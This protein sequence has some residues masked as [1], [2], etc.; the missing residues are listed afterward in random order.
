[1]SFTSLFY[2]PL[3]CGTAV[4][5]YFLGEK[6]RP[7]FLLGVSWFVYGMFGLQHFLLLLFV[8]GVSFAVG[9]FMKENGKKNKVF[10]AAGTVIVAGVL[11]YMK[12]LDMFLVWGEAA[13]GI[14]G[15]EMT[16][17][18]RH[19]ILP[20]G[21]SFYTFQAISYM[22]DVYRG[23]RQERN[24]VRYALYISFFPQ[25]VAG[26]IEQ[27]GWL[28]PQINGKRADRCDVSAGIR[29]LLSGYMRKFVIA[30][31]MAGFVD[32]AYGN[33]TQQGG[34][35]LAAATVF[36][37]I[38]IYCD[39]SGYTHIAIGSA[40]LLGIRLTENFNRPYLAEG[41]RDFWGRWHIT[42]TRWFREYVYIPLGGNRKGVKRKYLNIMAVF[43]LSGLWHGAS[44]TFILWG[45][46]F[47]I[48]RIVED[49]AGK[50]RKNV[51]ADQKSSVSAVWL[52]RIGTFF[53]V[54]TAWV[55]FRSQNVTEA[56]EVL[57]RI[58]TMSGPGFG[59]ADTMELAG[60]AARI[61]VL[62]VLPRI[63]SVG[64]GT[65][66][67]KKEI[68]KE[69]DVVSSY[70][71]ILTVIFMLISGALFLFNSGGGSSFI[72]FQF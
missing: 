71:V 42:L 56:A 69:I 61:G 58:F 39:F 20:A 70:Y 12:Y 54:C 57:R 14:F 48:W 38:Q 50:R 3:L 32:L 35:D 19:L 41:C 31:Y 68:R 7:Y 6:V 60:A 62:A 11:F 9:F 22:V 16:F 30:D 10:L 43:L 29:Y 1:M 21:I 18:Q 5:Y 47:G 72:Y 28:L 63:L 40:R 59:L 13:A 23:G 45:A 17:A 26:P 37:A 36:F 4:I 24:F 27:A 51:S 33:V 52:K 25:L 49:A 67:R 55:L 34:A 2:I 66:E 15:R 53:L 64:E 8:T 46:F 44:L 65:Q